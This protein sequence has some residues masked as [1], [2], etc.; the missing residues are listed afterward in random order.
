ME[1]QINITYYLH[2][3][4]SCE[5][6]SNLFIFDY[7][8]GENEELPIDCQLTI[9]KLKKYK[10]IYVLI[11]HSH[12]DHFDQVVYSWYPELPITYIVSYEM[13][14]GTRGKRL[15]PGDI[16][17]VSDQI[18]IKAYTS[19]DLGVAYLLQYEDL[20]IF[21]AGDLNYWH[22]SEES[23]PNEINEAERAFQSA[24]AEIVNEKIDIAFFPVDPRQGKMFD[25]GANYFIMTVK[26]QL[27]IPMHFWK[28]SEIV[29]EFARRC[30][31]RETEIIALTNP[32]DMALIKI[33]DHHYM[34]VN[35]QLNSSINKKGNRSSEIALTD[36]E[37]NDPFIDS[38]LPVEF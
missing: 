10:N 36:F 2:S 19:T 23:T 38:D 34:T 32:G 14:I 24:V 9:P 3:G 37:G 35:I 33:M 4:F 20:K 7:W 6:D 13:P 18:Q 16:L 5:I 25:A 11:T 30:R 29:T 17:K 22:W 26:P 12:P 31:T 28:R 8:L 27:M 15:S 21:H 1:K